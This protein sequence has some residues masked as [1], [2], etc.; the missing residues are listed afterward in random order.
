MEEIIF[1]DL[2]DEFHVSGCGNSGGLRLLRENTTR[3]TPPP[4]VSDVHQRIYP[5]Q[6]H[7][8]VRFATEVLPEGPNS[9]RGASVRL[10]Q[11]RTGALRGTKCA[12]SV[13]PGSFAWTFLSANHV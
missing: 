6:I 9:A 10:G 4:H 12:R 8:Q 13:S 7:T 2:Q 11:D 3:I 1:Q 5:F